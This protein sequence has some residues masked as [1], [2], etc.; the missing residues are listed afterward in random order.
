M[1]C[2]VNTWLRPPCVTTGKKARRWNYRAVSLPCTCLSIRL[3]YRRS[4]AEIAIFS[5]RLQ[6]KYISYRLLQFLPFRRLS[7]DKSAPRLIPRSPF[8][9]LLLG[10]LSRH[11]AFNYA[12]VDRETAEGGRRMVEFGKNYLRISGI[13]GKWPTIVL[14][15]RIASDPLTSSRSERNVMST[16][17]HLT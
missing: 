15:E 9:S 14:G 13:P 16:D 2:D 11:V 10:S 1:L 4:G 12:R 6:D 7:R 17:M 8:P 5:L 3:I